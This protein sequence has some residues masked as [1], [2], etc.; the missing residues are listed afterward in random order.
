MSPIHD[1]AVTAAVLA[2][3]VGLGVWVRSWKSGPRDWA[4]S[5]WTWRNK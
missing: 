4:A 1:I 3:I 5:Y 2:S